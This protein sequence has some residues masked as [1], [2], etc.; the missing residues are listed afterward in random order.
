[1]EQQRNGN[2]TGPE[3]SS[4]RKFLIVIF[5]LRVAYFRESALPRFSHS[6][7]FLRA[8]KRGKKLELE[9]QSCFTYMFYNRVARWYTYFT[10]NS[11]FVIFWC[12][13]G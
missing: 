12:A 1:M 4:T 2:F 8:K 3:K 7:L 6:V 10:E 5:F 13:F 9:T 11:H